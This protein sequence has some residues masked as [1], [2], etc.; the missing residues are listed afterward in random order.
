MPKIN[1]LEVV[2]PKKTKTDVTPAG[3]PDRI[4]MNDHFFN[5]QC[6]FCGDPAFQSNFEKIY[7]GL[8]CLPMSGL[9]HSCFVANQETISNLGYRIRT[10]EERSA[11]AHRIC[12]TCTGSSPGQPIQCESLDCPWFYSRRNAE[13]AMDLASTFAELSDDLEKENKAEDREGIDPF[14]IDFSMSDSDATNDI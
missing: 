2:S 7:A 6:L 9:C 4:N 8:L 12:V 3:S 10:R 1:V 5:M 11:N 13:E 14:D